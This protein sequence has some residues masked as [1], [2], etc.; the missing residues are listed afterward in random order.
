MKRGVTLGL[1]AFVAAL[2]SD[3]VLAQPAQQGV[4]RPLEGVNFSRSDE[5]KCLS[6]AIEIGDPATGPSTWILKAPPG[7]VVPWH[8]H[9]AQEQ[10]FI[11]RGTALAEMNDNPPTRLG[12]GGFAMMGAH[13]P[14]QFS[15]AGNTACLMIVTF[16]RAYDIKWGKGG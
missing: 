7:C 6:E 15:C 9:T 16:D 4:M 14:H 12:P 11:I 10:L 5:V 2:V 1:V 8:A 3:P 13:M